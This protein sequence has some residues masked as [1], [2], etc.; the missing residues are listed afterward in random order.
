MR[1]DALEGVC[2]TIIIENDRKF[3]YLNQKLMSKQDSITGDYVRAN[4]IF[5]IPISHL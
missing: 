4:I 2:E 5:K 1:L 3:K